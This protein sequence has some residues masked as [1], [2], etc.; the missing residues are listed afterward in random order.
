MHHP[1]IQPP[2][3]HL[4]LQQI[5]TNSS[6][7]PLKTTINSSPLVYRS[8]A[9]ILRKKALLSISTSTTHITFSILP[10]ITRIR[11]VLRILR[12]RVVSSVT[13]ACLACTIFGEFRLG[14]RAL[15]L[16]H[17]LAGW[18]TGLLNKSQYSTATYFWWNKSVPFSNSECMAY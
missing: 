9:E 11:W 18:W 6:Q 3:S 1:C 12:V 2:Q 16:T 5:R 17:S 4:E 13:I 7:M 10:W 15:I 8:F 14:H